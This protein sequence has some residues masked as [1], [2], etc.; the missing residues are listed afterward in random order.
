MSKRAIAREVGCSPSTIDYTI[1][2]FGT[3]SKSTVK[4]ALRGSKYYRKW[5]MRKKIQLTEEG[6]RK[7]L[8]FASP[9]LPR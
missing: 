9:A 5:R 2:K 8:E 1:E 3:P 7:W 4:R 6:A